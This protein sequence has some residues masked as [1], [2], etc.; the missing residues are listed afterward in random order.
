[1]LVSFSNSCPTHHTFWRLNRREQRLCSYIKYITVMH[2]TNTLIYL[3]L[4]KIPTSFVFTY[5]RLYLFTSSYLCYDWYYLLINYSMH[6]MF[7]LN[8]LHQLISALIYSHIPLAQHLLSTILEFMNRLGS[9]KY[10]WRNCLY[11]MTD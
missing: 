1:M 3:Y 8:L 10:L 7:A 9:I 2:A 6:W 5:S 4:I 11:F